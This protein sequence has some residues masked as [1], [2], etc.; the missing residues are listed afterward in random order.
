MQPL[1]FSCSS[2]DV[3]ALAKRGCPLPAK[4]C[5]IS[6]SDIAVPSMKI[7]GLRFGCD[8]G[9]RLDVG[10][11]DGN[12]AVLILQDTVDA[13]KL[14]SVDHDAIFFIEVWT[15]NHIGNSRFIFKTQ[16]DETFGCPR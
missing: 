13:K 8:N 10:S 11:F 12:G 1:A 15:H 7:V 4:V 5:G 2:P 14:F 6:L 3:G 16:K 9:Y